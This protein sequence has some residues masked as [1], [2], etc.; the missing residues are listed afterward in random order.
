MLI[1]RWTSKKLNHFTLIK[2]V[3]GARRAPHSHALSLRKE[4]LLGLK[5]QPWA[6]SSPRIT[7]NLRTS[8]LHLRAAFQ[9]LS[10]MPSPW[11]LQ[12]CP[13]KPGPFFRVLRLN[14]SHTLSATC[15]SWYHK[16]S[17]LPDLKKWPER[18]EWEKEKEKKQALPTWESW[19]KENTNCQSCPNRLMI[20]HWLVLSRKSN[21]F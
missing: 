20:L 11:M 21:R 4:F 7:Q 16:D 3:K 13:P 15:L 17:T 6:E 19:P 12:L 14:C 18:K 5:G 9:V 2:P 10:Q 8:R 1:L